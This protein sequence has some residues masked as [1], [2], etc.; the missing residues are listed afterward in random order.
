MGQQV[1]SLIISWSEALA[2]SRHLLRR[3]SKLH[4]RDGSVQQAVEVAAVAVTESQSVLM[5]PPAIARIRSTSRSTPT[6]GVKPR[7]RTS[8]HALSARTSTAC[9]H[10]NAKC[11]EPANLAVLLSVLLE[12]APPHCKSGVADVATFAPW[13]SHQVHQQGQRCKP[14]VLSAVAPTRP[15]CPSHLGWIP[16]LRQL[17][18]WEDLPHD[19]QAAE[20][21]C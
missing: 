12:I 6:P 11:A 21:H 8:G 18:T 4:M 14:S 19:L 5:V 13:Q 1:K 20:R 3:R 10:P 15:R 9:R 2:S 7:I 17:H 16:S